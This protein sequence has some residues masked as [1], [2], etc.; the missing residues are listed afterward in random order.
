MITF[1]YA[2]YHRGFMKY[3]RLGIITPA[4]TTGNVWTKPTFWIK[5]D[6][7][8]C[9]KLDPQK[10]LFSVFLKKCNF[11]LH[12]TLNNSFNNMAYVPICSRT[13]INVKFTNVVCGEHW[14][15]TKGLWSKKACFVSSVLF[16]IDQ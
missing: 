4:Y 1:Q 7:S 8:V 2:W 14:K 12:S 13:Y 5:N 3:D 11:Y 9:V 16:Q 10:H 6:S 15:F